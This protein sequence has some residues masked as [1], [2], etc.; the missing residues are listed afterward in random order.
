MTLDD[1][2][3]GLRRRL[4]LLVLVGALVLIAV[5]RACAPPRGG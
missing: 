1:R 5:A 2:S 3:P 4:G